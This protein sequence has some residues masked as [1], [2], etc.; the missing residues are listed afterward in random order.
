MNGVGMVTVRAIELNLDLVIA[1]HLHS[2][3]GS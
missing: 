3:L 2:D 1:S